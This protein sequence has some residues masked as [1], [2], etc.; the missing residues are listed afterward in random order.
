MPDKF[1]VE[2]DAII[3]RNRAREIGRDA[4]QIGCDEIDL[5][6][7]EFVSRSVADELVYQSQKGDISL[8]GL[9]DEVE[10]MINLIDGSSSAI[11]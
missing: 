10:E 3:T 6:N 8:I 7:V 11:A 5:S 2:D 4:R 1:V 9:R